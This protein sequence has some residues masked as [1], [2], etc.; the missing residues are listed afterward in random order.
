[1]FVS[2]VQ[3][4]RA[5]GS[6]WVSRFVQIII[7]NGFLMMEP[8]NF[9]KA[10]TACLPHP[11]LRRYV[12]CYWT[13]KIPQRQ[14]EVTTQFIA[15]GC[16][17]ISFNM[18]D[19]SSHRFGHSHFISHH[20]HIFGTATAFSLTQSTGYVSYFNIRFHPGGAIPFISDSIHE[21]TDNCY[22]VDDVWGA[23]GR[24]L[25]ERIRDDQISNSDRCNLVDRFL[26]NKLAQKQRRSN[27]FDRHLESAIT[28]AINHNGLISV[29]ALATLTQL[30]NRQLERKFKQK[31]GISPKQYCRIIRFR[32]VLG[33]T[34][35]IRSINW[36]DIALSFGYYDQSHLIHEF[37]H[38]TGFSPTEYFKHQSQSFIAG[39]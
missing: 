26:L 6:S 5:E 11:S 29:D 9:D 15:D 27:A 3:T 16:V 17:E 4:R 38:F 34:T 8:V 10:V 25:S 19:P 23:T 12:K 22:T 20:A 1:M 2:V 13:I 36:A 24:K 21:L 14:E 35:S 32:N 28:S 39:Y 33:K 37:R 7:E 30:S 18:A 31:L